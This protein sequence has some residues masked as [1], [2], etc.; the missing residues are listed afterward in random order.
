MTG[1]FHRGLT[2]AVL[3]GL[4]WLTDLDRIEIVLGNAPVNHLPKVRG[5]VWWEGWSVWG[6]KRESFAFVLRST[7]LKVNH[8]GTQH[9]ACSSNSFQYSVGLP[10]KSV[11]RSVRYS[12]YSA[13]SFLRMILLFRS[14]YYQIKLVSYHAPGHSHKCHTCGSLFH[15]ELYPC[16]WSW[17]AVADTDVRRVLHCNSWWFR[18]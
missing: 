14:W 17:S 1:L 13:N 12:A 6:Q 8:V 16:S 18:F 9:S 4:I 7:C 2:R 11:A 15:E 10:V 3:R 5:I